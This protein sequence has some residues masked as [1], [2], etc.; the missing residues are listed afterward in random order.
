[1]KTDKFFLCKIIG[2]VLVALGHVLMFIFNSFVLF[3]LVLSAGLTL[4]V[5]AF[6]EDGFKNDKK[7]EDYKDE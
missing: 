1:M 3:A 2:L 4:M 5:I 7:D 6:C